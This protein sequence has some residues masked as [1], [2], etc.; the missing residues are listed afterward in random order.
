MTGGNR[1]IGRAIVERFAAE[2]ADV[3]VAGR[4]E[5]TIEATVAAVEAAGGRAWGLARRRRRG[6]RISSA[7]SPK[8]RTAGSASTCSSTTPASATRR[9]SSRSPRRSGIVCSRRTSGRRSSCPSSSRARWRRRAAARSSTSPRST[10]P[11]ATGRTRATTPRRRRCSASTGRWR[12]SSAPH[13]IRVNCVSPGFTHT[14]MTEQ[15]V[16]PGMMDY[17]LHRFDRVPMRRLVKPEEVAAACAYLAS[18]DA[19]A[20]TGIDLTVDCGLTANWYILETLA[21]AESQPDSASGRRKHETRAEGGDRWRTNSSETLDPGAGSSSSRPAALPRPA[22]RRSSRRAAG[23]SEAAAPAPA[24]PA[25]P[26]PAEPAGRAEPAPRAR[27]AG[28]RSPELSGTLE[29]VVVGRAG[30]RRDPGMGRR[31]ARS[32]SRTETGVSTVNEPARH[33]PG[34]PAVHDRR[35][36][37]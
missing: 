3:L 4:N 10:R 33:E 25:E 13:G 28:P 8:R 16:P 37:R 12:S 18:D 2:G 20:I 11:A 6:P 24:E 35:R 21:D 15:G 19:S 26:P 1:G 30:G 7:S 9:R 31:D 36:G 27:R 17:L 34:D 29:D 14:D 5:E 32:S 23:T 22:W